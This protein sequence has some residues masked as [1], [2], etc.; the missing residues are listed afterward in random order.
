MAQAKIYPVAIIGG[1]PVGLA[2][3]ISL[4]LRDIPHVLFERYPSTSI[5]PKALGLNQR[6]V[7]LFRSLGIEEEVKRI[8]APPDSFCR[9][10]WYTC[11]GPEGREIFRRDAWGGGIY[12]EEYK[13][14]SPCDYTILPQ[15]RLEPILHKRAKELNPEGIVNGATVV[16]IEEK[17]DTVKLRVQYGKTKNTTDDDRGK[18]EVVH[19][20]YVV[21]ADG[22]RMAAEALGIKMEG[23]RDIIDMVS[24]HMRAPISRYHPDPNVFI[25]WFIDPS[26]G[27]SIGTG[28]LYHAGPYPMN[29]ETEEW[30]FACALNP[31]DPQKFGTEDMLKRIHQ[32]LKIPNLEIELKSVSHWFVNAIVA[33]RFRSGGG[34]VFLA[35]DTA[36]RI[37]PWGALGLNTGL[38]DVHNLVWKL[39]MAVKAG[40]SEEGGYDAL[41][42]TYEEERRPIALQVAHSSLTNLRN[43]GL[44]MDRAL[45]ILPDAASDDNVKSLAA[46]LDKADPEGD[47]LRDAVEKAQK[48]LDTEF[49]APGAEIGWFYPSLDADREGAKSYHGGQV[50]EKGDM[51]VTKYLPSAI[52]GHHLPHA[53]LERGEKQVSTRDLVDSDKCVLIT[54]LEPRTKLQSDLVKIETVKPTIDLI[55]REWFRLCGVAPSGA[56]LVRPDG[57]V[58]W[59][60]NDVERASEIASSGSFDEL[61]RHLLKLPSRERHGVFSL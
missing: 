31:N 46:F 59:R 61:V 10:A 41:L 7:E 19:A 32:T 5:H 20:R 54:T 3:S 42:D 49:H 35:G 23:E 9:T 34:R 21:A 15:I 14:A 56:I 4:S 6:S 8:R 12:A 38:Q 55:D 29:P 16:G 33:E 30:M 44:G 60:C 2:T 25:S 51:V 52:P 11:L 53:W 47:R 36:H 57:I 40:E 43:H 26:L 58:L 1:G 39:A 28:Y 27:G 24:A 17:N 48:V 22:G 18:E 45:G 50:T 13:Q 37:P